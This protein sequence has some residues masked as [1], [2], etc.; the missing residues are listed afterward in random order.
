[1]EAPTVSRPYGALLDW[2]RSNRIDYEVHEHAETFS[3]TSTA[4]AE[5]VDARTF[6]KVVGVATDD[7]RRA[8]LVVD[9]PDRVDLDKAAPILGA[10]NVRLLSEAELGALAVGCQPGAVPA[11]GELFGLPTYADYAVEV[12]PEISFNAGDHRYT[13]RVDRLAWE[14]ATR[15]HYANLAAHPG[16]GPSGEA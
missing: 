3:A 1:M 13:V 12:D 11:V 10:T 9:A 6:A 5:G 15:V 2:L 8:L 4:D 16:A 14:R 7:G